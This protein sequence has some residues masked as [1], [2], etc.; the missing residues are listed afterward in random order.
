MLFGARIAA[1]LIVV[2]VAL[3]V[4]FAAGA[5][6]YA[7]AHCSGAASLDGCDLEDFEGLQSATLAF[8]NLGVL[9]AIVEIALWRW[10]RS[11]PM[12]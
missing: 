4:A 6:H 2:P 11:R 7:A 5:A 10:R 8:L 12:A 3:F 9:V 1:Y